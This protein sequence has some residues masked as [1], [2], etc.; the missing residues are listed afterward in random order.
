MNGIKTETMMNKFIKV[1][2]ILI[3]NF[4]FAQSNTGGIVTKIISCN[5]FKMTSSDKT[6]EVVL[7][8][9]AAS[10]DDNQNRLA[11]DYLEKNILGKNVVVTIIKESSNKLYGSVLYNCKQHQNIQYKQNDIPCSEGNVLDIEMIKLGLIKYTGENDFL[12]SLG[13]KVR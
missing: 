4:S 6:F 7:N 13:S 8:D 2:F 12:K 5:S 10:D 9:T 3:V 1:L 11:K